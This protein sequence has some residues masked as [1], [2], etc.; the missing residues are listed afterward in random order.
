MENENAT[1]HDEGRAHDDTETPQPA[2]TGNS[3]MPVLGAAAGEQPPKLNEQPPFLSASA[4]QLHKNQADSA[5]SALDFNVIED[6]HLSGPGGRIWDASV[7]LAEFITCRFGPQVG[8]LAQDGGGRKEG[9]G[10]SEG[11][12]VSLI[13]GMSGLEV[14]E[15]GAGTGLAGMVCGKLG[16]RVA[17]TDKDFVVPLIWANAR[18]NTPEQVFFISC[19]NAYIGTHM[20]VHHCRLSTSFFEP[21]FFTAHGTHSRSL[22]QVER[23]DV[24]GEAL[25]WG[26]KL[27]KR[28]KRRSLHLIGAFA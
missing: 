1:C 6:V 22:P 10:S 14:L 17:I 2:G 3:P 18:Q 9:V 5:C 8:V 28:M 7:V 4:I 23:G 13:T 19:K 11:G 24:W 15:L 20:C 16:A 27:S 12:G 25:L 21:P 26:Q